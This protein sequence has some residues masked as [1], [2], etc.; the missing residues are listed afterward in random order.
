MKKLVITTLL[1]VL[2]LLTFSSKAYSIDFSDINNKDYSEMLNILSSY[3]ILNGYTDG[4]FRPGNCITRAEAAKIAVM[5]TGYENIS[6]GMTSNFSDMQGHWAERYVEITNVLGIVKGYEDNTFKPNQYVTFE[7]AVTIIIRVL[8]YNDEVVGNNYPDNYLNL[9]K[10]LN[11]LENISN[12]SKY[13]TRE[14]MSFLVYNSL[15]CHTVNIKNS[16]IIYNSKL[17]LNNLGRKETRQITDTYVLEHSEIYLA[18]YLMNIFDIYYDNNDNIVLINNPVYTTITGYIKS[19]LPSNLIFLS[20]K[21]GNSKLYNLN[22]V[23]IVYN[24]I[25]SYVNNEDLKNSNAR[26]LI[27][28]SSE[29]VAAVIEKPTDIKIISN[30]ELYKNSEDIFAGKYLPK[31]DNKILFE[32]IRVTGAAD[33]LYDIKTNDVVYFYETKESNY[34][35]STV[36]MEVIRNNITNI[37]NGTEYKGYDEYYNIG[38][39]KYKLNANANIKEQPSIGDSV[40]AILDKDNSIL[41]LEVMRYVQEPKKYALVLGVNQGTNALPTV[42]ILKHDGTTKTYTLKENSGVVIKASNNNSYIYN[43]SI[44]KNDFIRYDLL[45]TSTIKVVKKESSVNI[46]GEYNPKV[47]T[48]SSVGYKINSLSTIMIYGEPFRQINLE[49]L[50]NHLE[51]R[52]V[53]KNNVI[54]MLILNKNVITEVD[55]EIPVEKPIVTT[56]TGQVYG[57]IDSI[58]NNN[59]TLGLYNYSLS[60]NIHKDLNDSINSYKNQFVRFKVINSVVTEIEAYK[61]EITKSKVTAIYKNQLQIDGISLVEY[62]DNV[63]VYICSQDALGEYISFKNASLSDVKINSTVQFY[64]TDNKYNGVVNVIVIYN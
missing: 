18:K 39:I 6:F 45:N 1:I 38:D 21:Y 11:L 2:L 62:S 19:S 37:F 46:V 9:A 59:S 22:D 3:K 63:M 24:N 48:V 53:L 34:N 42:N 16:N 55:K 49:N 27:S 43:T 12:P 47:N 15:N 36:S 35:K 33:N 40:K 8:G 5:L 44:S 17:L 56:Y 32:N 26:F 7:E 52:A 28:D 60:F 10:K 61:P 58:S 31:K 20:D 50:G 57:A 29:I 25:K 30:N 13:M 41:Q 64:V 14:S 23:P 54:Q 4:T 51:G